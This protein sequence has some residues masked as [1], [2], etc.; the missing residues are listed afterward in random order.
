MKRALARSVSGG[1]QRLHR[2]VEIRPAPLLRDAMRADRS[3]CKRRADRK[4][5]LFSSGV[6]GVRG[7]NWSRMMRGARFNLESDY[8][9]GR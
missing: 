6:A 2:P 9:C 4:R 7:R 1:R 5:A 3:V 8:H